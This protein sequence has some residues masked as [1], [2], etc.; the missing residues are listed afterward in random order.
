MNGCVEWGQIYPLPAV[1]KKPSLTVEAFLEFDTVS[2]VNSHMIMIKYLDR[3]INTSNLKWLKSK[4]P[5]IVRPVKE[6]IR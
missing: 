6:A 4:E 3:T 5:Q 1:F 2:C